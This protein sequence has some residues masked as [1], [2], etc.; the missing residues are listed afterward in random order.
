MKRVFLVGLLV[1][2]LVSAGSAW[3]LGGHHTLTLAAVSALPE[4]VP[5]F[6]REGAP[7]IAH[8]S[9]DPDMGKHKGTPH[10]RAA[11]FPEHFLDR[12]M[13]KAD[14]LPESRYE[15]IKL[16]YE[17]NVAPE[18]IGL[19][20]YA[21]GEW[22]ERLAVAFA[23]YRKWPDNPH[24]QMKCLIYAGFVAHYAED[25][26]QPLHLTVHYNGRVQADG[27]KLQK[28]IHGKVDGLVS[29]L[30]MTP[31]AL[32]KN[33]KIESLE[34][35]MPGIL[36]QFETGFALV[37]HVYDLGER[38]PNYDAKEWEK[39]DEVIAFAVNRAR[40]SVRF[41]SQLYLTAWKLSEALTFDDYIK[42]AEW[43]GP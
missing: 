1:F 20:P 32:A 15:F 14:T 35:L 9:L 7:T 5:A 16:C 13:L 11:E 30:K 36:S 31:E 3:H 38:I 41:T 8:M 25:M 40:E 24:I 34:G 33:Q 42:R 21:L 27:S 4:E 28:G 37:D 2:G 18:K 23:E 43:D 19:V 6:F 39:D 17:Y 12:E 29:F 10:V 26:C 22:T